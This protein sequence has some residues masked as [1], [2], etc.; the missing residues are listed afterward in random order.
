MD[1][2]IME[3]KK[4]LLYKTEADRIVTKAL[5]YLRKKS[6]G[7]YL[8]RG[9]YHPSRG[10]I[11]PLDDAF[12]NSTDSSVVC[13]ALVLVE[14][15]QRENDPTTKKYMV[16]IGFSMV[17]GL[18]YDRAWI[19]H[20]LQWVLQKIYSLQEPIFDRLEHSEYQHTTKLL[21]VLWQNTKD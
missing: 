5:P 9:S 18:Q 12:L 19:G 1:V 10:D 3:D 20:T 15:A 13:L 11:P 17:F 7:A 6:E 2:A 14:K 4:V 8:G 21:E 16:E